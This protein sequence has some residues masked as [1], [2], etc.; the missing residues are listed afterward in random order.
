MIIILDQPWMRSSGL[1][2]ANIR[3][4]IIH[5]FIL[6]DR[7]V[8]W[9]LAGSWTTNPDPEW[10]TAGHRATLSQRQSVASFEHNDSSNGESLSRHL[11][12]SLAVSSNF[13]NR[14]MNDLSDEGNHA[15][16]FNYN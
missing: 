14:R 2:I 9:R 4:C 3:K 15:F 16:L 6:A 8:C 7:H 10:R 12:W 1:L 5:W 13:Q 11:D